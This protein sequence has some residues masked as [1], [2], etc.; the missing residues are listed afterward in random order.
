MPTQLDP[1]RETLPVLSDVGGRP[2]LEITA[3]DIRQVEKLGGLGLTAQEIALVLGIGESTFLRWRDEPGVME[4][5]LKGRAAANCAVA[6]TL[7]KKAL[8]GDLGACIWWEKTRAKRSDRVTV[9]T[10]EE[11]NRITRTIRTLT[12]D[13][14]RRI[15]DGQQPDE[16][17]GDY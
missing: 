1:N 13:Q 14:L 12:V 5:L 11:A 8:A 6:Q 16:V 10:E 4:A 2:R 3:R 7:Y 17:I 15:A 9:V